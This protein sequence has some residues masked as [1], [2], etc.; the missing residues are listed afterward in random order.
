VGARKTQTRSGFCG[1]THR[2][3]GLTRV[4]SG[5]VFHTVAFFQFT[6]NALA[7]STF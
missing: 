4:A 3:R 2:V 5:V 6:S 1:Q 7:S